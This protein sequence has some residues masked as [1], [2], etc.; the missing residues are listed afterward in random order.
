MTEKGVPQFWVTAMKTNEI[1][2][3]QVERMLLRCYISDSNL[4]TWSFSFD[5]I[6]S[7]FACDYISDGSCNESG[8]P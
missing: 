2:A 3:M 6:Y 7:I 8:S 4:P 1:L 5:S